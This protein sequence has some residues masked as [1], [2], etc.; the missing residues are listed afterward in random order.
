[1]YS[2]R[3]RVDC[4]SNPRIARIPFGI[5]L[6]RFADGVFNRIVKFQKS[7]GLDDDP[8]G[9]EEENLRAPLRRLTFTSANITIDPGSMGL[10]RTCKN[11]WKGTRRALSMR[12]TKD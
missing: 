8:C 9:E 12:K 5:F 2:E 6:L 3:F 4:G 10:P 11:R 1:M 7:H